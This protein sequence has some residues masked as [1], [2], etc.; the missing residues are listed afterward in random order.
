MSRTPTL[1]RK[2][3]NSTVKMKNETPL[4]TV[5][6]RSS[7]KKHAF[8]GILALMSLLLLGITQ[9]ARAYTVTLQ[10][11][12]SNVVANGSGAI[13]LTGLFSDGV[14]TP[15]SPALEANVGFIE[16]GLPPSNLDGYR[17][18]THGPTSFGSGMGFAV[19]DIFSGDFVGI[20]GEPTFYGAP[21]LWVPQGYVSGTA[22]S[23]SMTFNNTTLADLGVDPGTYVW[24]WGHG[25]NQNFTLVIGSVPD[26][27]ST[28][29]LL[30][31]ALFGL[32]ALRRKL[33]C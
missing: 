20:W 7:L 5:P 22:L 3:P 31:C 23:D 21:E 30:G 13:N 28:V 32:V 2:L 29:A 10:Q 33:R 24:H 25:A 15:G 16:T 14:Y 18:F 27:G 19:A 1:A 4:L 17:G 9:S 11:V 12:G 8:Y 6:S 26:G